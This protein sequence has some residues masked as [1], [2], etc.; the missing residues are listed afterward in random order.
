LQSRLIEL[1]KTSWTLFRIIALISSSIVIILS[2][3]LPLF[4]HTSIS[5][6]YLI[7]MFVFLSSAAIIVHGGLTHLLNDY[8]DYQSGTDEKS[9][10]VLSGGS[11]VIQK[12]FLSPETVFNLGKWVTISLLIIAL[13]S[14]LFGYFEITILILVGVWAAVSYSLPPLQLSYRPFIGEWLS[15]FPAVFFIGIAGP[16]IILESIPLWAYQNAL[17]NGLICMTW[18]MI[19]HIPDLE[20][21]RAASPKKETSIVWFIEKFGLNFAKY[22]ALIYYLLALLFTVWILFSRFWTGLIV[23]ILLLIGLFFINNIRPT[24]IDQVTKIEKIILLSA[25]VIAIVLGIF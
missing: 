13:I 14:V 22:P 1:L 12:N 25:I 7:Y 8:A 10:A 18:V 20:A 17:I 2:S 3:L 11:R 9:P 19:H 21:D 23:I 5:T 15:M 4:M 16:W 24:D 6:S